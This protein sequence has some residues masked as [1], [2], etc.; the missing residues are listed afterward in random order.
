MFSR[1]AEVY[2]GFSE[3]TDAQVGR[4][5]DYLEETGQLDNTIIFYCADNG[6]SGEGSPNGSVN[7]GKIFGGYPDDEQENLRMVDKLGSPDTYNHYPTGWAAAFS[8]PYRMFKRYVYQGGVCDPM[9]IHWPAGISAKGEIRNQ[10]HHSTDV[11]A[12]I[13]DVCGVSMPEEYNGV[14][15]RPLDGVSMRYS[16]DASA[17][18]ASEKHTQYY[19][20]FGNRGIWHDGWKAV[21]EHGPVS[22]KGDFENDVWQ[23]FHTD[24]DRSEAHDVA[25]EHPEKLEE[26]KRLWMAEAQRNLVLP[27]NDLQVIGNPKDF[28]TFI[29]MEFHV[30]VPPSGQYTYYPGTTE[31]PERSAANVHGVSYKVLAEVDTTADTEGVIFAHGSRFGGHAMFVKDG[32]LTYAYNFLGIPPEADV[33]APLPTPGKHIFGVEFTKT[34]TGQYREATGP[35]KLYIDDELVAQQ[36]IR[37]VLGHFSLC[38]EG[39]CIGYDSGDAVSKQYQGSRFDYTGGRIKKVVFDIADDAYVDLEAHLAAAM[40]R[41]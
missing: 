18:G 19:E 3:Y 14:A 26:L 21:T 32:Q 31:V 37:T 12:T 9:V 2:A 11:V 33:S 17:D 22:G 40:A 27:L 23:L 5:V 38:G 24:V 39:L 30:P 36:D 16:F 4:I 10:Y 35:L 25:A 6:A 8:T 28:E 34:G 29:N 41:D 13:L 20:M 7:E 15:Q 1:M